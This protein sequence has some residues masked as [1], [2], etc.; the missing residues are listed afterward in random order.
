MT[1]EQQAGYPG[2]DDYDPAGVISLANK[3]LS[4]VDQ[5]PAPL[6]VR[7]LNLGGNS[8]ASLADV[9]HW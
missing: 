9:Q 5:L 1:S 6:R 4:K 8:L 2:E 7:V 3:K